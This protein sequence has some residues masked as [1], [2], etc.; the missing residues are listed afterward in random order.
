MI[1]V[2]TALF[3]VSFFLRALLLPL[4]RNHV[5]RPIVDVVIVA[6]FRVDRVMIVACAV[7]RFIALHSPLSTDA[8]T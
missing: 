6:G 4:E 7:S 8:V 5:D 2:L 3:R 1:H